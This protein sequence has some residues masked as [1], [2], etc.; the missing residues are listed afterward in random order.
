MRN[1]TFGKE[2]NIQ[3][4]SIA[5]SIFQSNYNLSKHINSSISKHVIGMRK[6]QAIK[7]GINCTLMLWNRESRLLFDSKCIHMMHCALW[8][9]LSSLPNKIKYLRIIKYDKIVSPFFK[10][11]LSAIQMSREKEKT[12]KSN[13]NR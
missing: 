11:K 12:I 13:S 10:E 1:F 6:E 8:F 5:L 4:L 3:D 2:I 7:K 9:H